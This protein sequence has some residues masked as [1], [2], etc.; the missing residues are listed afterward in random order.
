MLPRLAFAL[1]LMISASA[2]VKVEKLDYR[3]WPNCYRISNGTVDLIVTTDVGPR[4]IRY[5]FVGGQNMFKE[6]DAQMGRGGEDTWQG[7]GGH[8]IWMAPEDRVETYALDNS[9]IAAKEL[10][11]G[12]ELTGAVE[13]ETGLQK[14][15]TVHLDA[16]GAGVRVEHRLTNASGKAKKFA[17]WALTMMA[18]GGRGIT[19]F[20]PRARHEDLLLPTNP[21]TMWGFTDF[22]DKRWHFTTKYLTLQQDPKATTPLKTGLFSKNTFGAYLLGSDLF[23]KRFSADA[24]KTYPDFGCSFEIYTDNAF[25]EIETLGPL[26]TV[27]AGAS[28]AHPERWSLTKDVHIREWTDN[29]LDNVLLPLLRP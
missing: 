20:P 4:V 26:A 11:D 9:P 19:G 15:I 23:L 5:G 28:V 10:P 18:Q 29:E 17:P 1:T 16:T 12:M 13:K 2:A 6:F 22:S 27:K 24:S 8:R 7:R 25:L 3:G 14:S 21:L